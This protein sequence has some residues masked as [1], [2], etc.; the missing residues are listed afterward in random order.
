MTATVQAAAPAGSSPAKA[1]PQ[2]GGSE[3]DEESESESG[4]AQ[5]AAP[6][7]PGTIVQIERDVV[8]I[9]LGQS[10]GVRPGDT[11][12]VLR[13]IT[14]KHPITRKTLIDH[15]PI[16]AMTVEQVSQVL[17]FG[18]LQRRIVGVVKVGDVV[19]TAASPAPAAEPSK[20]PA[21]AAAPRR[22]EDRAGPAVATAAQE[23]DRIFALTRGRAP[24]ER[25]DILARYLETYPS[26]PH[27][28]ALR[29]DI[30]V[31]RRFA[32]A[33][34]KAL[35]AAR[36]SEQALAANDRTQKD[37]EEE[38]RLLLRRLDI[39]A[40]LPE[41]LETGDRAALAITMRQPAEVQSAFAYVRRRDANAYDRISLIKDGDGYFRGRL[42]AAVI[43][44]PSLEIF[45]EAIGIDGTR[46]TAGTPRSPIQ[47]QV[48]VRAGAPRP[49]QRG[50]S[51]LRAFFEYVDFN[52]F[53]RNDYYLVAEGDFTYRPGTWLAGVS[54]GFGVLY[55]RGGKNNDLQLFTDPAAC[56]G[57]ELAPPGSPCGQLAGFNYGYLDVEFRFG[58][59]VSM[60]PR[61][62]VGQSV[63]GPGVGGELKLRIG[64][65]LGTNLQL[66]VSYFKDFGALGSLH[67]E[68]N[69]VRGWPMGASVIVTNLPAQGDVGVRIVYQI[70]YRAR[71]FLQPALRVG[72]AARNI[73]QIGLSVGLGLIAAW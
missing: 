56:A 65:I 69:V 66:G 13:T 53:K 73:E 11:L 70:A 8:Y 63:Q 58:K 37:R 30:D 1:A 42:P 54:T 21:A 10:H 49:G 31:F 71:S 6:G 59:W 48:D 18:R 40:S 51:E 19:Q 43:A 5:S 55:G 46:V 34:R 26:S 47:I 15:F 62:V 72:V 64:Q 20:D 24:Q 44:P 60:A 25:A 17:S 39:L 33:H 14:A 28:D 57:I 52:R 67:L 41:R 4:G 27:A 23:L 36:L 22:A 16:G 61:V 29:Q 7:V 12:R 9:D 68:W 50:K 45:L 32:E 2:A 35:E 3:D 38:N